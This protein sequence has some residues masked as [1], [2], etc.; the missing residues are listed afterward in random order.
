MKKAWYYEKLNFSSILW[1]CLIVWAKTLYLT[2][3]TNKQLFQESD[4]YGFYLLLVY[5]LVVIINS[6]K[7]EI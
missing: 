7:L 4:L 2:K 5:R 3:I 1:C 6:N